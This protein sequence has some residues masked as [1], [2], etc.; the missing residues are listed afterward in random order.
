MNHRRWAIAIA[1]VLCLSASPAAANS[2]CNPGRSGDNSY[3]FGNWWHDAIGP[4]VTWFSGVDGWVE[5]QSPYVS[6]F[7]GSSSW[8]MLSQQHSTKY[9]QIGYVDNGNYLPTYRRLFVQWDLGGG[10]INQF[11][12]DDPNDSSRHFAITYAA[13]NNRF[14][15]SKD[16]VFW[17]SVN[18]GFVPDRIEVGSETVSAADQL[19][20]GYN[21][22]VLLSSLQFRA[23]DPYLGET[24]WYQFNA[25]QQNYPPGVTQYPYVTDGAWI[26]TTRQGN[27]FQTWDAACP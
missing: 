27:S 11:L 18:N 20:G 21:D 22:T 7:G 5:N 12:A 3:H 15:V 9:I 10:A 2:N 24:R 16:G 25:Q 1:L 4:G 19:P 23:Y 13:G 17:F 8:I 14:D 6:L 26:K